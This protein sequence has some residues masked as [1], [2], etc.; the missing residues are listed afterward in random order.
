MA[1]TYAGSALNPLLLTLHPR[2]FASEVRNVHL[3]E[4]SLS[5]NLWRAMKSCSR[6][7]MYLSNVLAWTRLSSMLDDMLSRDVTVAKASAVQCEKICP[8]GV[9]PKVRRVY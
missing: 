1:R 6:A 9:R 7:S 8:A 2:N 5:P 4:F 3:S